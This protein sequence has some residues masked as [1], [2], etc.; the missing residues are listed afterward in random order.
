MAY[1][2]VFHL[3]ANLDEA[4][5]E[6]E[7]LVAE[8][9]R[10]NGHGV[11]QR[12]HHALFAL[13]RL[14]CKATWSVTVQWGLQVVRGRTYRQ[15]TERVAGSFRKAAPFGQPR[16]LDGMHNML[17]FVCQVALKAED[18][19]CILEVLDSACLLAVRYNRL[20]G[21]SHIFCSDGIYAKHLRT[22]RGWEDAA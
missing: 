2:L 12:K 17:S 16:C 11:A 10:A 4:L 20:V 18:Q 1:Q 7:E 22:E 8:S 19:R 9:N 14:R 3:L 21:D 15:P 5:G 6:R 13:V